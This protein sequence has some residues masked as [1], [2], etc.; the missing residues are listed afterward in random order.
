MGCH[1]VGHGEPGA[2]RRDRSNVGGCMLP[3]SLTSSNARGE[4][5]Q[6]IDAPPENDKCP[7]AKRAVCQQ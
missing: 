6:E 7:C 1:P 4:E 3:L 2:L 5:D